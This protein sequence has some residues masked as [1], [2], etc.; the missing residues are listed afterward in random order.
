M[1]ISL[2]VEGSLDAAVGTKI[3]ASQGGSVGPV[4]GMKG[5]DYVEN[6]IGGFNQKAQGGPILTLVDLMDTDSDCPVDVVQNWLPHRNRP[7]LFRLVVREIE[8]WILADRSGVARF[9]GLRTS[10]IPHHPE[11]L[12]DPKKSLITLA[13]SSR[14]E[15]LRRALVPDDPTQNDQGPGYT[16]RMRTFVREK[17]DLGA[18]M[19]NADSLRRCVDAVSRLVERMEDA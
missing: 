13:Q 12:D 7:M 14:Y 17:W 18:A 10:Q 11:D 15:S 8:S 6:T 9:L 3:I 4:Y 19:D 5:V 2:L 16:S 1:Q